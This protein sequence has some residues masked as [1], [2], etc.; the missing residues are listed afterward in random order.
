[1]RRDRTGDDSGYSLIE[2]LIA[3]VI[4]STAVI[5][6]LGLLGV[7]V[8][9]ADRVKQQG[10]VEA[11]AQSA[12]EAVKAK[13]Y[14]AYDPTG[15]PA[16]AYEPLPVKDGF[17]VDVV[18]VAYVGL[19]GAQYSGTPA[20]APLQKV[21]VKATSNNLDVAATTWVTKRKPV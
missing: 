10:D 7:L 17:A 19:D 18:A 8:I 11:L 14:N 9:S 2:L 20:D 21:Q 4:I 3:L 13:T 5:G 12:A 1:M 6:V 16:D 15:L